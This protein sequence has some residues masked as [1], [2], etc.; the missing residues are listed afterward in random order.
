MQRPPRAPS[1]PILDRVL[2]QRVV[3]VSVLMLAGAFGLFELALYRGQTV[4]E[5]RTIA[6]NLLVMVETVYLF[7][8]RSLTRPFW[9]I[10]A[11]ANWWVWI[12][13]AAMV[14]LQAVFTYVPTFNRVFQTAPI[15]VRDWL[16]IVGF[17]LTC[18]VIVEIDKWWRFSKTPL[19]R[20]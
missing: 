14:L 3:M 4:A 11:F 7:N 19:L 10:G 16:A 15:D 8:C 12:G 6:A 9:S 1:A 17:A 2:V 18:A 13:S 5:G 20:W